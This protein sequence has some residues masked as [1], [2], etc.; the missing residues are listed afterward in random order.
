ML[1][2]MLLAAT[3]LGLAG[4]AEAAP[5]DVDGDGRADQLEFL[6]TGSVRLALAA[7][8][9]AEAALPIAVWRM[10]SAEA[11]SARV[12]GRIVVLLRARVLDVER[13][14]ERGHA[15]AWEWRGGQLAP[16]F[17]ETIGDGGAAAAEDAP[18]ARRMLSLSS[19][20]VLLWEERPGH[21]GCDGAPLRLFERAWDFGTARFRLLAPAIPAA[22]TKVK[23]ERGKTP[24]WALAPSTRLPFTIASTTEEDGGLA[25]GLLAPT[26]LGDGRVETAWQESRAGDGRGTQ[27]IART[28]VPRRI[29]AVSVV[30]GN[31]ATKDAFLAANRVRALRLQVDHGAAIDLELESDP[32]RVPTSFAESWFALLPAPV[33]ASCASVTLTAVYP[34][35][36]ARGG[37]RSA[38]AALR[39]H[40]EEELAGAAG[41]AQELGD[42]RLA[43]RDAAML[44]A[45]AGEPGA[46]AVVAA[47]GDVAL[48]AAARRRLE[49]ALLDAPHAVG[50]K[51]LVELLARDSGEARDH[52]EARAVAALARLGRDAVPA[53]AALLADEGAAVRA[54]GAAAIVLGRIADNA[55]WLAMIAACGHGPRAV[56]NAV[57][58]ALGGRD[59][60]ELGALGLL[61]DTGTDE[62]VLADLARAAGLV[63][64]RAPAADAD[65]AAAGLAMLLARARGFE[66][67]YRVVSALAPVVRR[68]AASIALA[69][70]ARADAEPVLRAVAAVAF[71]RVGAGAGAHADADTPDPADD[72]YGAL[73]TALT[74]RDPGVRLAVL[75]ALAHHAADPPLAPTVA[76]LL[77][78]D[79]WPVVRRAAAHALP[80]AAPSAAAL[81]AATRA[82]GDLDVRAAA[83]ARFADCALP[84]ADALLL[85]VARDPTAGALRGSAARRLGDSTDP[86]VLAAL[87][88][89]LRDERLDALDSEASERIAVDFVRA[90]AAPA[91]RGAPEA[92]TALRLALADPALPSLQA[93]AAETLAHA[94]PVGTRVLLE[95]QAQGGD[96]LLVRAVRLGL[97]ECRR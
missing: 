46:R 53:L 10:L 33:E 23:L 4:R 37:G 11:E 82:D 72:S 34:A 54:R 28:K 60:S 39:L 61:L 9:G 44:L 66:L 26:E 79:P 86:A 88:L 51:V 75:S 7:G 29:V 70:V 71:A 91:R 27:F 85:E 76:A 57:A 95:R 30:P 62:A 48:P 47:L 42:G 49:G 94:C 1:T 93:T 21:D 18:G 3:L 58:L 24:A 35:A 12:G 90:L 92:L 77:T 50:T 8:G 96:P 64:A 81:A 74:D 97:R 52:G 15:T 38:I 20:A 6:P 32:A 2:R 45:G 55:A 17:T 84:G 89:L 67:R 73:L 22:S 63:A 83:L 69:P 56:R 16:M 41:V 80:C 5:L 78:R 25:A 36:G 40:T 65:A 19:R 68:A 87:L 59:V 13:G 31:A 14:V 43:P